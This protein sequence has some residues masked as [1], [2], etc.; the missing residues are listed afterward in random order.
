[1]GLEKAHLFKVGNGRK[2]LRTTALA[3]S[4]SCTS[5]SEKDSSLP[6]ENDMEKEHDAGV[7]YIHLVRHEMTTNQ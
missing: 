1:M 5:L 3:Q 7:G 6:G 2:S 4:L